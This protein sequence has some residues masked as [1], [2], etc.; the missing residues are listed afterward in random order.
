MRQMVTVFILFL[1]IVGIYPGFAAPLAQDAPPDP[2]L[3]ITDLNIAG[4]TL[5]NAIAAILI[6]ALNAPLTT[7]IVG[8]LKRVKALEQFSSQTLSFVVA[9]LLWTVGTIMIAFGY[10]VQF[11]ATTDFL[12]EF[13]PLFSGLV[14]NLAA[15]HAI[16]EAAKNKVPVV[17]YQRTTRRVLRE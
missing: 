16:Y 15:G 11:N 13:L 4:E 7:T 14:T 9:G 8:L 3:P 10:G 12:T 17:G 5:L 1:F 2:A 6:G